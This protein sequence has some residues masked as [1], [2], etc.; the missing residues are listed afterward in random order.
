VIDNLAAAAVTPSGVIVS[1]IVF[2]LVFLFTGFFAGV[3]FVNWRYEVR[4]SKALSEL[5]IP[6]TPVV[7]S[8]PTVTLT[9]KIQVPYLAPAPVTLDLAAETSPID[10]EPLELPAN[11]TKEELVSL[12]SWWR[13][14]FMTAERA[15]KR[16]LSTVRRLQKNNGPED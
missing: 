4:L 7:A 10:L 13:N 12:A 3:R 14:R 5:R 9:D 2:V 6:S 8:L 16:H 11:P 15:R 1:V